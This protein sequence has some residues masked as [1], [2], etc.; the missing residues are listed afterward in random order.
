[1]K[2][3]QSDLLGS[4][5]E[6]IGVGVIVHYAG[7]SLSATGNVPAV[8][9]LPIYRLILHTT[10]QAITDD[11][12]LQR[13][14]IDVG[15]S[16]LVNDGA[17]TEVQTPTQNDLSEADAYYLGGRHYQLSQAQRDVLVSAGYSSYIE[18]A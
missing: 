13:F 3:A 8:T 1:V 9:A 4:Q 11:Y 5:V 18:E 14:P 16:L 15:L 10:K 7:S 17:V 6:M 2:F 12:F